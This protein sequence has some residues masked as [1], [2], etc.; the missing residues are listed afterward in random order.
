MK[1]KKT[2]N[3]LMPS[4]RGKRITIVFRKVVRKKISR[5]EIKN[6]KTLNMARLFNISLSQRHC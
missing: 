4:H 3:Q 2:I 1:R 6:R 5:I